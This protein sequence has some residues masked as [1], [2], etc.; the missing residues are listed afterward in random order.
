[1]AGPLWLAP[2]ANQRATLRVRYFHPVQCPA[3]KTARCVRGSGVAHMTAKRACLLRS[4][5]GVRPPFLRTGVRLS[6]SRPQ[7]PDAF[8]SGGDGQQLAV[9]FSIDDKQARAAFTSWASSSS[10]ELQS[11]RPEYLPM[12]F[13]RGCLRATYT[14]MIRAGP[15]S[16]ERRTEGLKIEEQQVGI[17]FDHSTGDWRTARV[18]GVYAGF[19]YPP[20]YVE[21]ALLTGGGEA[22]GMPLSAAYAPPTTRVGA[23]AMNPAF[24]YDLVHARLGAVAEAAATTA[25]L[26][27]SEV[28]RKA[29]EI[30]V[31]DMKHELHLPSLADG[32]VLLMPCF[33]CEYTFDGEP[34]TCF[35]SG[36]N[37]QLIGMTHPRRATSFMYRTIGGSIGLLIGACAPLDIYFQGWVLG[38]PVAQAVVGAVAGTLIGHMNGGRL[39]ES[40]MAE[41]FAKLNAERHQKWLAKLERE[42]RQENRKSEGPANEAFWQAEVDRVRAAVLPAGDARLVAGLASPPPGLEQDQMLRNLASL[43]LSAKVRLQGFERYEQPPSTP[44]AQPAAQRPGSPSAGLTAVEFTD[45]EGDR[46]KLLVSGGK[47]QWHANGRVESRNVTALQ[48]S[49]EGGVQTISAPSLP[50]INLGESQLREQIDEARERINERLPQQIA[51]FLVL[52]FAVAFK[53]WAE[54]EAKKK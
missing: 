13:F 46:S 11:L 5:A 18:T 6:S 41:R 54:E 1:M 31:E 16:H 32:G 21:E 12:Y 37:G 24:A 35:V 39:E 43:A 22:S 25:F 23:F 20:W 3:A 8:S 50:K 47:L 42:K 9:P 38:T 19:D 30:R 29:Y 4:C 26:A 45:Q 17:G 28:H 27:K 48:L 36:I 53:V 34:Y 2:L 10:K 49:E 52:A 7:P 14:G 40:V 15:K 44:A 33:V 51:S